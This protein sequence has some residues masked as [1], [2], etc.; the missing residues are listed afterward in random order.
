MKVTLTAQEVGQAAMVGIRRRYASIRR[1]DTM[2]AKSHWEVDIVGA[3]GECAVAKALGLYWSPDVNVFK[4]PDVGSL[5]VRSTKLKNGSLIIRPDDPDGTYILAVGEIN[6][7]NVAGFIESE[8]AK[9]PKF[10][11]TDE[12][13]AW[14]VPQ[15]ALRDIREIAA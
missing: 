15:A 1:S 9:K 7:F 4:V 14:F 10:W 8:D 6:E 11:K 5:H 13:P 2:V 12:P 3:L